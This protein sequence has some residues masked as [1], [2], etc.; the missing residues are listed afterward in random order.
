M[1]NRGLKRA[2]N[3]L[4]QNAFSARDHKCVLNLLLPFCRPFLRL[5]RSCNKKQQKKSRPRNLRGSLMLIWDQFGMNLQTSPMNKTSF[6]V[7]T[8]FAVSYSKIALKERPAIVSW[9]WSY[10]LKAKFTVDFF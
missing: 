6:L 7:R 10:M 8:F 4:C 5:E 3:D 1:L 9:L 2:T